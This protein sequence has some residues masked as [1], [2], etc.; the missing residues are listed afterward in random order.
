VI[1]YPPY[2]PIAPIGGALYSDVGFQLRAVNITWCNGLPWAIFR[3]YNSTR[4]SLESLMLV[5]N[6]GTTSSFLY[7]PFVS[8]WPFMW[9]DKQCESGG[10][11][12]LPAKNTLYMGTTLGNADV[13]GHT[14]QAIVTLCS[15]EG[16]RGSC[17]QKTVEFVMP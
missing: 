12:T 11:D 10:I 2:T 6:D 17:Y 3:V 1:T 14:I 8:D 4:A 15:K 9:T 7:G 13:R 16:L 5:F